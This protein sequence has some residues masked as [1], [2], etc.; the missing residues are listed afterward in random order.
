MTKLASGAARIQSR[1]TDSAGHTVSRRDLVKAKIL[2][3]ERLATS[4]GPA[5]F[6]NSVQGLVQGSAVKSLVY[7][8]GALAPCWLCAL[9]ACFRRLSLQLNGESASMQSNDH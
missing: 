8:R 2:Q 4:S 6:E 3:K 1:H 9:I 5:G 7:G